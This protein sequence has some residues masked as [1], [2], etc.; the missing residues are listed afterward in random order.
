MTLAKGDLSFG[1]AHRMAE[2]L[3]QADSRSCSAR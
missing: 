1:R 2:A 3:A